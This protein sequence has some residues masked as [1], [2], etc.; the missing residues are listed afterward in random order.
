MFLD[1]NSI[2]SHPKCQ[3]EPHTTTTTTI[4]TTTTPCLQIEYDKRSEEIAIVA[5]IAIAKQQSQYA[6]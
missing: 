2:S 5:A 6:T 4:T 1:F 3:Q